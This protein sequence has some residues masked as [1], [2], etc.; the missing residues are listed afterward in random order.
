MLYQAI[1]LLNCG[2]VPFRSDS[3]P[4]VTCG[5][6]SSLDGVKSESERRLSHA[7]LLGGELTPSSKVKRSVVEKQNQELL[8]PFYS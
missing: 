4:F 1:W 7:Y 6:F 3:V 5:S 2:F 8:D